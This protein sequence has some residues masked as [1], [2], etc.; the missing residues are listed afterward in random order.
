MAHTI[1]QAAAATTLEET[2]VSTED[3]EMRQIARDHGGYAPFERPAELA[4]DDA[5]NKEVVAHALDWYQERGQTFDTVCLLQVTSPFRIADD[6]DAAVRK[7][8][9]TDAETVVSTN[10]YETPPFWAVENDESTGYLAPY[11]GEEYL[12]SKTQTQ[13]VPTLRHP[14]GA[15]FAADVDVFRREVNFYTDRT[16]EYEMPRE[17]AL[18]ID[19]PFDLRLARALVEQEDSI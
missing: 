9:D 4:T 7:L 1:E 12:W 11:F 14:N 8:H 2:V 5:T 17:R 15:I 10:E 18:D 16:V 3:D 6:I 19:E 13:S